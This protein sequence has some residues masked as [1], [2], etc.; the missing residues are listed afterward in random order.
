MAKRTKADRELSAG[1]G[2]VVC[3]RTRGR[4][5]KDGLP[6][7]SVPKG[8]RTGSPEYYRVLQ[9]VQLAQK[10]IAAA[11]KKRGQSGGPVA[12]TV[13]TPDQWERFKTDF[14]YACEEHFWVENRDPKI[15]ASVTLLKWNP[16]QEILG[17]ELIRQHKA[18]MPIRVLL[19][20]ARQF[21]GSTL[22][23][24]FMLWLSLTR[25]NFKTLTVGM[26]SDN[27]EHLHG[28]TRGI[29][30]R[31][32]PAL[33]P[34]VKYD[35]KKE[36]FFAS[37]AGD[38]ENP[39]LESHM[40]C[41]TAG[42]MQKAEMAEGAAKSGRG[43]TFRGV[44]ASELAF[45]P[46]PER[47]FQSLMGAVPNQA[48]TII[49]LESTANLKGDPWYRLC[50]DSEKG[51]NEFVFVFVPWNVHPEYALPVPDDYVL[52]DVT[53][54]EKWLIET[55]GL[56]VSQIV[57]R[58]K[59]I[60]SMQFRGNEEAFLREYPEDP[61]TCFSLT[62]NSIFSG[63]MK[64][65]SASAMK[66]I[67]MGDF[68]RMKDSREVVFHER[69]GGETWIYKPPEKNARYTIGADCAE[70]ISRD[71]DY[72]T[73]VVLNELGG[74]AAALQIKAPPTEFAVLLSMLAEYYNRAFLAVERN[75]PGVAVLQVLQTAYPNLFQDNSTEKLGEKVGRLGFKTT[76]TSKTLLINGIRS[77]LQ[78]ADT[79]CDVRDERLIQEL[80]TFVKYSNGKRQAAPGC[81]DDMVMAYGIA[82]QALGE[83][84]QHAI[85]VIGRSA[86][87]NS[88]SRDQELPKL[89]V[90]GR[91]A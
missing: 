27:S 50:K 22:I 26:D 10:Q 72:S 71:G 55:R 85:C 51:A 75:G 46:D 20:K 67:M 52:P 44:H 88:W 77:Y 47:L 58:R 25:N 35:N 14:R 19:L 42:D 30:R 63:H 45:W 69:K 73:A 18:G 5:R 7:G 53:E 6:A 2:V 68:V 78:E 79:D 37:V 3:G 21:G 83:T 59:T 31:L 23:Q 28:I 76:E 32:M 36:L 57:W 17:N 1:A 29:V 38:P 11:R 74:V 4:P 89:R 41:E 34:E 40:R 8:V 54:R 61:E 65:V 48:N 49:A 60:S 86:K 12:I 81:H 80:G 90:L 16:G 9:Q 43:Y 91:V 64:F 13:P 24:A 56:T 84:G 66:P 62:G 82:H 33:R 70:G 39:G 87:R 15:D